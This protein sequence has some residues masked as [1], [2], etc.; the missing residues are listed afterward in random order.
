MVARF[1]FQIGRA[2]HA[3]RL[4]IRPVELLAEPGF[5]SAMKL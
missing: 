4:E 1:G 5:L 3:H 2:A